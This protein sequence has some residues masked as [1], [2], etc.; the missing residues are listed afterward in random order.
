M[1]SDAALSAWAKSDREGGS[2]SL[3]RHLSDSVAV[4]DLVWDR[5]LPGHTK[6]AMSAGLPAGVED[7]R[8]LFRWLAGVH[9]IGKLTPAFACQVW[10]LA[11]TM[12]DKGLP[13]EREPANRRALPHGL[14]G[15]IELQRFL[16]ERGWAKKVAR[17][18]SV[19]VGSHHGMTPTIGELA[20]APHEISLL[21]GSPWQHARQELLEHFTA[22]AGVSERLECWRTCPLPVTVQVLMTAAVIIS[23]WIASKQD[24][25]PLDS[26]RV[27][28]AEARQAWAV[29]NLPAP[30]APALD[31]PLAADGAE[32]FRARFDMPEGASLR[33]LQSACVRSACEMPEPGVMVVEAAMGEG[34]T[35]A[36]LLAAE[37]LACR[38]GF[39]GVFV[40][41]PTMATSDA[42]FGRVRKWVDRL[43][44]A[45]GSMFLAHGKAA[46]NP[47]F[48]ELRRRG[49]AS[50]GCDCG[51]SGVT[52]HAWY[53]GKKGPLANVVVGTI[54]QVLRAALKTRHV[55]LRHLALANKVVVIDEVHAA[56]AYMSTYLARCLEWLGAYQVPVILLSATLPPAQRQTLVEAYRHGRGGGAQ[57]EDSGPSQQY[58]AVTVWPPVR[59]PTRISASGR[60]PMGV[61]IEK[62]DDGLDELVATMRTALDAGGV[63]G[64]VCNT[65]ARAQQAY[66]ALRSSGDFRDDELL[67]VHS[68]FVSSHRAV[69]ESG[70][71]ARLGPP[72]AAATVPRP[73]RYVVVGTQVMEQSLDIDLDLLVSDL[74]PI[75]LLLQRIGRLHRHAREGRPERVS[76]P[77]CLLRGAQWSVI[78]PVPGAGSVAVYGSAR[79]LRAAAVLAGNGAVMHVP[80]DIPRLVR[81]A[82]RESPITPPGWEAAITEAEEKWQQWLHRQRD[83]AETYLLR[84]PVSARVT[85][86]DWL[87]ADVPEGDASVG[88][89]AQ[90]R[91]GEDTIEAI[92]VQRRGNDVVMLDVV[93]GVGGRPV[94]IEGPPDRK[95]AKALA[96]C[97][98]RLPA[99]LTRYGRI[100]A[101]IDALE[102]TWYP[103]WQ[104]VHWLAGELVLELDEQQR[105]T[106]AGH[107]LRYDALLGLIIE[108]MDGT[109]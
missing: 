99:A 22:T 98:I 27:S 58:P 96:A 88:G 52:A 25:F 55:M 63:A 75:D 31:L 34:K 41:L 51:D 56:D 83:R 37:V 81:E 40:A 65:V 78:P 18:Y 74:A 26:A 29:L 109:K 97:T 61:R 39:G 70:L 71:R 14:A 62:I 86:H 60:S 90:V 82:Y 12:H 77:R 66:E 57:I 21:G 101:V 46:L 33:P 94:P 54:D 8:L 44:D 42:M 19:V 84:S 48:S 3:F 45:A 30:W 64:I 13:L 108:R 73:T 28:S 32:L 9:D 2:L 102:D 4:A 49:F 105:A 23:D 16:R 92:V 53:V 15:D 24:L 76:M 5:W 47:G 79:L 100:G 107:H 38:F 11:E 35:E 104:Q 91:D 68:R 67:L 50:I 106:L 103:G 17:T 72:S 36:A 59:E 80:E 10:P 7:G 6:E 95:L 1:L 89:Q 85:L 87:T 93:P 69:L 20:T 43:P